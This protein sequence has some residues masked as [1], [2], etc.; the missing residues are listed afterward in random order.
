[1]V[2]LDSRALEENA[3]ASI[4]ITSFTVRGVSGT[5]QVYHHDLPYKLHI[6]STDIPR[7]K[8]GQDIT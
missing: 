8:H 1:M 2:W 6:C 3:K 4:S 7:G 5:S